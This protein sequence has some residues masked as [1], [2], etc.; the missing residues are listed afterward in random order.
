MRSGAEPPGGCVWVCGG[1]EG[2][3][4]R[5]SDGHGLLLCLLSPTRLPGNGAGG[6]QVLPQPPWVREEGKRG[7][8][9]LPW[10]FKKPL[11]CPELSSSP[12]LFL[13]WGLGGGGAF[14]RSLL[15]PCLLQK[16]GPLSPA[17]G[18]CALRDLRSA[19][20]WR[21]LFFLQGDLSICHLG[22]E[23]AFCVYPSPAPAWSS[24]VSGR[25]TQLVLLASAF[26][27]TRSRLC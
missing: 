5:P 25:E 22:R 18:P 3:W 15:D 9:P 8:R 24:A 23:K 17:C 26:W 2:A 19:G 1:E 12:A 13:F 11:P 16:E 20:C 14:L 6:R 4:P 7:Y 27:P 21:S 10:P